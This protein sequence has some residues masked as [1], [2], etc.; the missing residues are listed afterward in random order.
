MIF[1]FLLLVGVV[2][3][4]WVPTQYQQ[5]VQRLGAAELRIRMQTVTELE[6]KAASDP[7]VIRDNTVQEA[8]VILLERENARIAQD[9]ASFRKT[10]KN[11]LDEVYGEYYAQVLGLANRVRKEGL[12]PVHCSC[13]SRRVPDGQHGDVVGLLGSGGER[14]DV[15]HHVLHD[16]CRRPARARGEHRQQSVLPIELVGRVQRLRHAV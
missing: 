9:S 8:I 13:M 4:A 16:R 10:G 11:E 5:L 3:P 15:V 2:A 7:S 14:T 12:L 6:E 1:T